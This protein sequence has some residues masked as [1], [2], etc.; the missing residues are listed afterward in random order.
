MAVTTIDLYVRPEDGW[1]LAATAPAAYLLVK[2]ENFFPWWVVVSAT[3]PVSVVTRAT[4]NVTFGGL[5]VADETVTIN[6]EVYTFKAARA[7]AFEVTIGADAEATADNLL[8]AINLD[9]NGTYNPTDA[10]VGVVTITAAAPGVAGNAVTLAESATNTTVSG[11]TLTGG[12]DAVIGVPM[13]RESDYRLEPFE[14]PTGTAGNV[15]I[16]VRNP[17]ASEPTNQQARFAVV[18]ET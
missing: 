13:G 18:A 8:A 10:G 1:V 3:T 15:Y 14:L 5:P 16:R 11:A 17:I 2:P 9:G 6:G 7:A 4:G 12:V